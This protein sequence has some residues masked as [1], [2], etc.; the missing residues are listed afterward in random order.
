MCSASKGLEPCPSLQVRPDAGDYLLL[1]QVWLDPCTVFR[2]AVSAGGCPVEMPYE[3][4]GEEGQRQ[5]EQRIAASPLRHPLTHGRP[6]VKCKK[7]I[8]ARQEQQRRK[9][10]T[11]HQREHLSVT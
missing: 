2:W 11:R 6:F 7:E 3:G 9:A 1:T 5:S 8:G 10:D 4:S